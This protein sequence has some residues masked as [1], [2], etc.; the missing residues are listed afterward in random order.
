M[1][2]EFERSCAK[3]YDDAFNTEDARRRASVNYETGRLFNALANAKPYTHVL[4][5]KR[6][7]CV[8][9]GMT[10]EQ[11]MELDATSVCNVE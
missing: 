6:D 10:S 8:K 2:T 1:N 11:M 7:Q 5:A 9:C 4:D 3:I